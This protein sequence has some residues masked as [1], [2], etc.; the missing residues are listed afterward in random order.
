MGIQLCQYLWN[1]L[2]YQRVDV[3]LVHILV[4][5]NMQQVV[6]PVASAVDNVQ[7]V[8]RKVIGKEVSYQYSNDNAQRHQDRHVSACLFLIHRFYLFCSEP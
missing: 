8:A 1:G 2:V 6:Q 5:D 4:V 3:H 7:S